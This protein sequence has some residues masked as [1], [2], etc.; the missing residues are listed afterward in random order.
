MPIPKKYYEEMQASRAKESRAAKSDTRRD[1]IRTALICWA[2]AALGL[3]CMAWSFHTTNERHGWI[4]FYAGIIINLGGQ[5]H[6]LA[7]AYRRGE[8]R[9]D[10]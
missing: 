4:A 1:L 7:G 6:T 10:W 8:Q 9:G 2:W 5:I 3:L